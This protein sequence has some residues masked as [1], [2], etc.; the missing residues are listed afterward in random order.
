[1]I[2]MYL[3]LTTMAVGNVFSQMNSTKMVLLTA[4]IGNLMLVS[5]QMAMDGE[6]MNF[7][8]IRIIVWKTHT[9]KMVTW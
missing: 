2:L 4:I 3:N 6:I 5:V 1:M 9:V 7:N 8:I